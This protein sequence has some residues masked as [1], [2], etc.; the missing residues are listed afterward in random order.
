MSER[1]ARTITGLGAL[2]DGVADTADGTVF[3]PFALPG[4]RWEVGGDQPP[5]RLTDSPDRIPPLCRHFGTCGGCAA[6]HMSETLYRT[7]K[8]DVV[9]EAFAHRGLAITVEP[10]RSVPPHSRRRAIFGVART[11]DRIRLGFRE[12][13]A[14]TLVDLDE[15]PVLERTIVTA[16]GPLRQIARAA[17]PDRASGRLIATCTSSGLDVAIECGKVEIAPEQKQHLA[18]LAEAARLTRLTLDGETISSLGRPTVSFG[19]AAIEVEPAMFLQ[20]V[21]EAEQIM[22]ALILDAV[23]RARTV[24]DLFSGAGT[25]TFPLAARARVLAVD[26]DRKAIAAL[27]RAA[28]QTSGLKPI[29][30]KVR[31]L[32]HE[33]LSRT[34]L[35]PFDAAVFDPPRAGAKAQAEALARSQVPTVVAVSCNPATL[36]RDARLL[37]DGGYGIE[38]IVPID[39]FLFTPH[40]EA[41]AVFRRQLASPRR[42]AT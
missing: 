11:G 21:P 26:G 4:E 18:C 15:C 37:V 32:F 7:W 5:A 2:G 17:L 24:V 27:K 23:G 14:H 1:A 16:L 38:R 42:R 30:T 6:Q 9:A 40:V 22:S 8:R 12:A 29:E 10:L 28:G 19:A 35:A 31:D 3:V 33:P 39:Q 34:E 41:V 13:G 25:F 36:A 20:A